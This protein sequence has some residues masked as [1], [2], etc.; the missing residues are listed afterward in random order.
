[1]QAGTGAPAQVRSQPVGWVV[2]APMTGGKTVPGGAVPQGG[3][4]GV[5]RDGVEIAVVVQDLQAAGPC[6]RRDDEIGN[7]GGA[8]L[9]LFGQRFLD[10][11]CLVPNV[12][13]GINTVQGRREL[14]LHP[15]PLLD[16]P[17]REEHLQLRHAADAD[18]CAH[19][20]RLRVLRG[21]PEDGVSRGRSCRRDSAFPNPLLGAGL[22]EEV[23]RARLAET[24]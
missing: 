11:R 6:G 12:L 7:R 23:E 15:G 10:L 17:G 16:V 1:M 3:L 19:D 22:Q 24:H 4:R 18:Q 20:Q 21:R 9:G 5:A 13:R 2:Y 8:V 14:F